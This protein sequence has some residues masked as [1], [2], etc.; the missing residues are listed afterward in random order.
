MQF[1]NDHSSLLFCS[2]QLHVRREDSYWGGGYC[3]GKFLTGPPVA[4]G[5][6]NVSK[7][8]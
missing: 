5:G 1:Q 7:A 6:Q 2:V 8:S 3:V 4:T